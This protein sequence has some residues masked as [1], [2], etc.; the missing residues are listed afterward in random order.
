MPRDRQGGGSYGGPQDIADRNRGAQDPRARRGPGG[1]PSPYSGDGVS[2]Q[3]S[4]RPPFIERP[5]EASDFNT[6]GT[7]FG[8]NIA[9]TPQVFDGTGGGR[10][11]TFVVPRTNVGAIR[12]ISILANG[13]LVTSNISWSLL[14]NNRPVTGWNDI[15]INPRAAGSVEVSWGPDETFIPV[16]ENTTIEWRVQVFDAGT[17]QL[18]VQMHGWFYPIS[19]HQRYRVF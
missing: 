14:F 6:S 7:L 8:R 13:L 3:L 1:W 11:A 5:E 17:Y 19:I 18:S 15:T 2:A 16:P 9:N 4:V 12:A 10:D